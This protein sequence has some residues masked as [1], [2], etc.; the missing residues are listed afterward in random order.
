MNKTWWIFRY[1]TRWF[2]HFADSIFRHKFPSS[3]SLPSVYEILW[4]PSCMSQWTRNKT[5]GEK[6][7]ISFYAFSS[8]FA[9]ENPNFNEFVVVIKTPHYTRTQFSVRFIFENCF[10]MCVLDWQRC[11]SS[12]SIFNRNSSLPEKL[13]SNVMRRKRWFC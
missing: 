10:P 4:K 2:I 11:F 7:L 6:R 5:E 3:F 9:V 8:G 12:S 1:K 13:F